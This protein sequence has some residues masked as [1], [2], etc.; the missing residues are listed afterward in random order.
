[1]LKTITASEFETIIGLGAEKWLD[2][3]IDVMTHLDVSEFT[4]SDS[5]DRRI[6]SHIRRNNRKER[7][8]LVLRYVKIAGIILVS[9]I[10]I[11]FAAAM[12]IQPVRAAFI[13]AIVQWC[14]NYIGIRFTMDEEVPTVIEEIKYPTY[15]PDGW[16]IEDG[17]TSKIGADYVITD[18]MNKQIYIEQHV[19]NSHEEIWYDNVEAMISDV[20]LSPNISAKLISYP[21][22]MIILTW[23]NQY[24][25]EIT[26][27]DGE[28][29]LLI[30]IAESMQ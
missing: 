16:I 14:D 5:M 12:M 4:L 9:V 18:G 13:D 15:L 19:I 30:H 6:R 10:S 17:F 23:E 24:I 2:D 21:D 11:L 7:W 27:Y 29:E 20:V 1:M 25:Y 22:G 3:E 8:S 28:V 26:D